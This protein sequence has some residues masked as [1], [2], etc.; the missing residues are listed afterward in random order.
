MRLCEKCL[1]NLEKIKGNLEVSL[2]DEP[3]KFE[4]LEKKQKIGSRYQA[5]I[6]SL[7][8]KMQ[9]KDEENSKEKKHGFIKVNSGENSVK[10]LQF[11][12]LVCEV[13]RIFGILVTTEKLCYVLT[14]FNNN[15]EECMKH[16]RNDKEAWLQ[17]MN[18]L[19]S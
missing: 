19:K 3:D 10:D 11:Q 9:K 7:L 16:L 2:N 8:K 18:N 14:F 12:T 6:P 15:V 13:Q 1:K 17:F 5:S 4:Y